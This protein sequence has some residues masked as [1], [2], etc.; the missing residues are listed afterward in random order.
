[1]PE[2]SLVNEKFRKHNVRK[3][4]SIKKKNTSKL[5]LVCYIERFFQKQLP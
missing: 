2:S 1:M 4:I 5:A 3:C